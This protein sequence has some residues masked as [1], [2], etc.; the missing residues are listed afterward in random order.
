VNPTPRFVPFPRYE[1][2]S[3]QEVADIVGAVLDENSSAEAACETLIEQAALSW[4]REEGDYRDD[5]TAIVVRLNPFG[6]MRKEVEEAPRGGRV[7][8]DACGARQSFGSRRSLDE[9]MESG[10]TM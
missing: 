1:F 5:I 10:G 8:F 9:R 2:L 3:S 4:R 7:L 6:L